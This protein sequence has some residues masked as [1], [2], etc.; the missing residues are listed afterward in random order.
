[1]QDRFEL[2]A[3]MTLNRARDEAIRLNH[4][5]VR[6]E[7]LL[8]SLLADRRVPDLLVR[9]GLTKADI[10]SALERAVERGPRLVIDDVDCQTEEIQELPWFPLPFSAS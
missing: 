7:H 6:S 8:L 5:E 9:M 3:K 10:R 1:M 4:D 2:E